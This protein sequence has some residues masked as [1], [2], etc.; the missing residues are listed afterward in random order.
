MIVPAYADIETAAARLEGIV[1]RTP[2][3]N[4]QALDDA[5]GAR[6][7]VKAESLQRFGAF[8]IR[9]AY[10]RIAAMSEAERANGVLAF[11][12]GNHAIGVAAAARMFGAAA[13]IVMP[14]DAPRAKL[15]QTRA[16]GAEIVTYDRAGESREAIGAKL[17]R[18]RGLTIVKPFDDPFVIAGQGTIGLEIGEEIAPDVLLAPASGGGLIGGVAIALQHRHP[19]AKAYAVEPAGHDDIARSLAAGKIETNAPRIRAICDALLVERMGEITFEIAKARLAGALAVT[20]AEVKRAVRFAFRHLKLVLEPSGAA[21]LA[22]ALAG[23]LDL[24]G[25]TVAIVASGGNVDAENF[26]A[27]LA[28]PD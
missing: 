9:G 5:L 21:A 22:A 2:L 14:A 10:N 27:I 13:L 6:V 20:D 15:E 7:F 16:L 3:L 19:H 25:Q 17:A 23:K 24:R 4:A 8:K 12:S 28:E 11:S 26:A 18:E 1:R